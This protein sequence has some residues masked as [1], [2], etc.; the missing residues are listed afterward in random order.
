MLP[1][2]IRITETSGTARTNEPV[3]HGVPIPQ[4]KI[5]NTNTLYLQ[6]TITGHHVPTQL[7]TLAHWPDGSIRVL[8]AEFSANV[9]GNSTTHYQLCTGSDV[10]QLQGGM[11]SHFHNDTLVIDFGSRQL[12]IDKRTASLTL[13]D[14][15]LPVDKRTVL[16]AQLQLTDSNG[17]PMLVSVES[18]KIDPQSG[19][20]RHTVCLEGSCRA[21]DGSV[22][23]RFRLRIHVFANNE[24][25]KTDICLHNHHAAEHP[26]G[27]WDLG[28]KNSF[29]FRNAS[30][31]IDMD[32]IERVSY[33]CEPE[34]QNQTLIGCDQ[35]LISQDSSGGEN[36]NGS[37]HVN[38]KNKVTSTF[39]GYQCFH[40]T[41]RVAT[42]RRSSPVVSV[43][44]LGLS[45]SAVPRTFWQNCPSSIAAGQ[46]GIV[47]NFFPDE[48]RDLHEIQPGERKTQSL[49]L[50][51]TETHS[52]PAQLHDP[53]VCSVSS[54][55][56][57]QA[58]LFSYMENT[59]DNPLDSLLQCAVDGK[60][61]FFSKREKID[62]YGWRNFGELYADHET[63]YQ[64][65]DEKA[66]VSHYNNQYDPVMG[67]A[68]QYMRTGDSRW[69]ELMNDLALHVNDIDIYHT[70][71]DRAEYNNGLFWH[72]DHYK[73]V[74]TATHRTFSARN[75]A[76]SG[77]GHTGGGPGP[78]HCYTTGLMCHYF[79]TGDTDSRASVLELARWMTN[80]HQIRGGF[81]AHV[82]SI[83]KQDFKQLKRTIKCARPLPYRF[84][85]TR[86]TGN[87]INAL[88]DAFQLTQDTCWLTQVESVI[89]NT[90]HP[91]DDIDR[92]DL[93]NFEDTWSYT[94]LLYSV[95]RY[96]AVK[97]TTSTPT[98]PLQY[99]TDSFL[100]YT[101]WILQNEA[102][103]R[104]LDERLEFPNDTWVAQDIRKSNLLIIAGLLD[105]P[106]QSA[107]FKKAKV[108]LNYVC[109]TLKLSP[110]RHF[111]RILVILM[112]NYG[113]QGHLENPQ[114]AQCMQS[115]G[116]LLPDRFGQPPESSVIS[117]FI[118]IGR[119]LLQGIRSFSVSEE[120]R[121]IRF[122]RNS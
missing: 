101:D 32:S 116:F 52:L 88:L 74:Q 46:Q 95:S 39:P 75:N 72:T 19:P 110:E 28:D 98:Q 77:S 66:H 79:L 87:Y 14:S 20:L 104:S 10:H 50:C 23:A 29:L 117:V 82:N 5:F 92:R 16:N 42:G 96:I 115:T 114:T 89:E 109:S 76:Q 78:E 71:M 33:R 62:E 47:Y 2:D 57:E 13:K 108:M 48:Y 56:W 12:Y 91:R 27:A 49:F 6:E 90:L 81:L 59:D 69:F 7:N 54:A 67:F 45:V 99:A 65:D 73:D 11:R 102:P 107:Y 21:A 41:N 36:W 97:K 35:L 100:H 34:E 30:F 4:S 37:V 61:S 44:R 17:N 118:S 83:Y 40:G 51:I 84:P 1:I 63:L 43:S 122:R 64:S 60:H 111:S 121:W 106:R 113:I 85:L 15:S 70:C 80:S 120:L 58:R 103:F 86:G 18:L 25:I 24:L 3:A 9:S 22:P 68:M 8:L 94:V 119:T 55:H 105:E 93:S 31:R 112:Q 53:L 26:G 38:S